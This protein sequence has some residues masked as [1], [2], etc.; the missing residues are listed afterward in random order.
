MSKYVS[1][2]N[3]LNFLLIIGF[4][5]IIVYNFINVKKE[6]FMYQ[7]NGNSAPPG[8]R[9]NWTIF[10][11]ESAV[12]L[13]A[14][15]DI[16][17]YVRDVSKRRNNNIILDSMDTWYAGVTKTGTSQNGYYIV[18]GQT[19]PPSSYIIPSTDPSYI[20]SFL[21]DGRSYSIQSG[22]KCCE[23]S[24]TEHSVS[25]TLHN[26]NGIGGATWKIY[27]LKELI[28]NYK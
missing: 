9:Y 19:L 3:R 10:P 22:Y 24:D 27:S 23:T 7:G 28:R 1:D 17:D 8:F 21:P 26:Y 11:G 14:I 25:M 5:S 6:G 15:T 12:G 13:N 2:S 18:F 20:S 4:L 16:I